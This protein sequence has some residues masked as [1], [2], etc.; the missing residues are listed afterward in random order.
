MMNYL[1]WHHH[2][3]RHTDNQL[4]EPVDFPGQLQQ[5]GST[6]LSLLAPPCHVGFKAAQAPLF[7]FAHH[8][9]HPMP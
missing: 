1:Y 6:I 2:R 7:K 9:S 4:F 5:A 3:H 8:G